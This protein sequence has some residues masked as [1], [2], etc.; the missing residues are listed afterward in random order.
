MSQQYI[1]FVD[2]PDAT[3]TLRHDS[4]PVFSSVPG[5]VAAQ[6]AQVCTL[7]QPLP[8]GQGCWRDVKRDGYLLRSEHGILW[9]DRVNPV[10]GS[11]GFD[12]DIVTLDKAGSRPFGKAR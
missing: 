5:I 4:G 7:D 9:L 11:V 12:S 10:T 3:V 2:P 6:Q 8:N 1:V